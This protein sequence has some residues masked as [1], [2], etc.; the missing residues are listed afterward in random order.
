MSNSEILVGNFVN[1]LERM[2]GNI[3]RYL[4]TEDRLR[5]RFIR[6]LQKVRVLVDRGESD[7][8]MLGMSVGRLLTCYNISRTLRKRYRWAVRRRI[9]EEGSGAKRVQLEDQKSHVISLD[10]LQLSSPMRSVI[11]SLLL[12]VERDANHYLNLVEEA[13]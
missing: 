7:Y 4:D 12:Q 8:R 3:N 11:S 2:T 1:Q 10:D 13:A 6:T 9:T 5:P